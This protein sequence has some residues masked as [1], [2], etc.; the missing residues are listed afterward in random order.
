[1]FQRLPAAEH[2]GSEG[3]WV[4]LLK[5]VFVVLLNNILKY[6]I[7]IQPPKYMSHQESAVYLKFVVY[8][9]LLEFPDDV[10]FLNIKNTL[11]LIELESLTKSDS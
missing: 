3:P 11:R 9:S 5:W 8:K 1:M 6:A 7:E 10:S 2:K 4:I